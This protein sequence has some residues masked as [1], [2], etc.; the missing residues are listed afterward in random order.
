MPRFH[1]VVLSKRSYDSSTDQEERAS[2]ERPVANGHL[3]DIVSLG[4]PATCKG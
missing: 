1:Q 3:E 4:L 2:V